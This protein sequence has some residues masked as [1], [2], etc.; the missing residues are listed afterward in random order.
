[1]KLLIFARSID[2]R[3]DKMTTELMGLAGRLAKTL[4]GEI[5]TGAKM[6]LTL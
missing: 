1:M 6:K 2:G 4:N 3:P 5:H